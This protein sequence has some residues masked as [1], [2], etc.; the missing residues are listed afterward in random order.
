MFFSLNKIFPRNL[1]KDNY[2]VAIFIVNYNMPERAEALYKNVKENSRWPIDIY[3][4]D[5]GSDIKNIAKGTNVFIKRNVQ[6]CRGWLEGLKA[7]QISNKQYFA[8]MF[9][10]TSANFISDEDPITPMVE[11]LIKNKKAVGIHPALTK[12]STTN[13]KHLITREGGSPRQTWMIDNI[14]SLYRADWF[15]SIGWFDKELIYAWG[16][17]LET[18]YLARKQGRTIWVDERVQVTKIT[19]IAYKMKRMNMS[20]DQR[21]KLAGQ[22]MKDI[23]SKRYGENYW[24]LMTEK[25]VT[26]KML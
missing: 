25:Y 15:D 18:C 8:Y 7:A 22:N 20:A 4:I 14:A 3:L 1:L 5:N 2:K 12:E 16:I 17:D 6:T 24:E 19:N 9:L 21:S 11:F 13:W 10:I 26:K 23:L